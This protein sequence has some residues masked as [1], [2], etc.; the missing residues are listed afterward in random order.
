MGIRNY[1][2]GIALIFAMC[3][4]GPARVET[5]LNEPSILEKFDVVRHF[6][7]NGPKYI[8]FAKKFPASQSNMGIVHDPDCPCNSLK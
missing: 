6:E 7:Y 8:Q 1:L 3:S 5:G 2:C 4:C